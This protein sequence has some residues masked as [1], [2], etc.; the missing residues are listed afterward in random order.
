MTSMTEIRQKFPMYE[1]LSDGDLLMGIHK[2]FYPDMHPRTFL[3]SIEGAAN[4]HVTIKNPDLKQYWRDR[5][6]QPI[7]GEKTAETEMRLGGTSFGPANEGGRAISAARSL[8][9]G[10]TFGYG[11]EAVGAATALATGNSPAFEMARENRRVERGG[12][13]FLAQS[14]AA[15]FGGAVLAPGATVKRVRDAIALGT[16]GGAAYAT[17]KE[18]G[19]VGE[20]ATAGVEAIPESLL[21][22]AAGTGLQRG[23]SRLLRGKEAKPSLGRLKF[24]Q[25]IAYRKV[26]QSNFTFP[27]AKVRQA[28]NEVAG[29]M[30][31]PKSSYVKGDASTQRA[32]KL[33]SDNLDGDVTLTELDNVRKRLWRRWKAAPGDEQEMIL[34]M[35]NKIDDVIDSEAGANAL[36]REARDKHA[37]YKR[38]ELLD[39]LFRRAERNTNV[40]GSG[41]NIYNNTAR[42]FKD[43][44]NSDAKRRFFTREALDFMEQAINAPTQ[45]AFLRKVGK[46]SPD[47]NGLMLGLSMIGGAIDP[48]LLFVGGVGAAA[49]SSADARMAKKVDDIMR[50]TAG[51]KPSPPRTTPT[52]VP[53]A[54]GILPQIMSDYYED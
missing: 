48:T 41:G 47:G 34:R 32:F 8:L 35:I 53:Y 26:D 46:L 29:E 5:V 43:V 39:T 21:F 28:V 40:S 22:S 2:K 31:D 20:R 18:Q 52:S 15:E 4:A 36:I 17:G 25:D 37:I 45:E 27:R 7:K 13:K 9:Q 19:T 14:V 50:T 49:K 10:M 44:L 24:N 6:S 1:D 23:L 11:D 54:T 12:E 3:N 42:V 33:M 30:A 16:L 51:M 38:Y